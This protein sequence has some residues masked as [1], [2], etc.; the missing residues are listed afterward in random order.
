MF[1]DYI[2]ITTYANL[3]VLVFEVVFVCSVHALLALLLHVQVIVRSAQCVSTRRCLFVG[4]G[5]AL[6][7][8]VL[9]AIA[10]AISL[11][12]TL[13]CKQSTSYMMLDD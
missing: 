1:T 13:P 12:L 9:L 8:I 5:L 7:I 10:A 2:W 11:P 3:C 4:M 6:V